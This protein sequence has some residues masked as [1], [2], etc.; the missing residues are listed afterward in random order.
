[1]IQFERYA[2]QSFSPNR[3]HGPRPDVLP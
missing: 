3:T 2:Y 1:V